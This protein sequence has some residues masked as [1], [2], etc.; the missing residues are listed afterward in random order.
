MCF[1]LQALMWRDMERLEI[2]CGLC[3]FAWIALIAPPEVLVFMGFRALR[4]IHWVLAHGAVL[5]SNLKMQ[6]GLMSDY[7]LIQM[8]SVCDVL[9]ILLWTAWN[10]NCG[11]RWC[12][13]KISRVIK[14][15]LR[16]L[17]RSQLLPGMHSFCRFWISG[18][19]L[20]WSLQFRT[21]W[22]LYSLP[23]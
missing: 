19:D 12:M 2:W 20:L 8:S 13:T 22:D 16:I 18:H 14:R 6:D 17:T 3:R 21:S 7:Q 4:V 23:R 11:E 9:G 5:R 15:R 10:H 1:R